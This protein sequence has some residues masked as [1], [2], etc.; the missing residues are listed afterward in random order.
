MLLSELRIPKGLRDRRKILGRGSSSG[1]GQT[2]TRGTKGQT[3][4]A[5]R[6]FYAGFEGGQ[7]PLI[8]KIPKRGF[9][10]H[11]SH[12]YQL[13]KTDNLV[14]VAKDG[15]VNPRILKE[16]GLIKDEFG[17][18]KILGGKELT[19]PLTV[20][21]DAFSETARDLIKKALG[22]VVVRLRQK[23]KI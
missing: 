23:A 16:R 20:E 3:S 10:S 18:I 22:K 17:S 4:R 9:V 15:L 21:A 5:G 1:H 6:H 8:R 19:K 11:R 2:S 13:V 7:T 12:E 14:R